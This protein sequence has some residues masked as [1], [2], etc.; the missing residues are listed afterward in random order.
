MTAAKPCQRPQVWAHRGASH[1][2]PENTLAAFALAIA[3]GADGIECDVQRT[4]DGVLVVTHDETTDRL[5]GLPGQ[6]A[7]LTYAELQTRNFAYAWPDFPPQQVPTLSEVLSLFQGT[8]MTINLELKNNHVPYP[9]LEADV[10]AEVDR[11]GLAGQVIYSSFNAWSIRRL[12]HL[13]P[14]SRRG[15]LYAPVRK[16]PRLVGWLV[17]ANALHPSLLNLAKPHLV[18]Q[19]HAWH[20]PVHVWT[21]DEPA[22]WQRCAELGVDAIITNQPRAARDFLDSI[23]NS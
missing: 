11:L 22:A 1:D 7:E 15:W 6:I 10:L 18:S 16:T 13:A 20:W 8:R 9:G 12:A 2:A 4:A 19:A 17:R 21:V 5:T 14:G 3:Q 23:G